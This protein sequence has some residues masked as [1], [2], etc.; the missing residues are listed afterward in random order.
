MKKNVWLPLL[1]ISAFA[2]L[3]AGTVTGKV[4]TITTWDRTPANDPWENRFIFQVQ[5]A[6]GSEINLW[7]YTDNKEFISSLLTASA[8]GTNVNVEFHDNP[9]NDLAGRKHAYQVMILQ[10]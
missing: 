1:M 3:F 10:N 4:K 5:P 9:V 2:P 8:A 7:A 6:S